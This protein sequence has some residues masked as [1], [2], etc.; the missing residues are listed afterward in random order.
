MESL[1]QDIR[2]AL[3]QL[4]RTPTLTC[5]ALFAL[6]L[7]IG[8]NVAI[9]STV[10]AVLLNSLPFRF[11]RQPDRLVSL[12]ETNPALLQV[13]A[14]RLGVT[15]NNF[16]WWRE[17][18]HSF[19]SIE[20][21]ADTALNMTSADHHEPERV[22]AVS[23]TPGFLP[24]LGVTPQLG[25]NLSPTP[26]VALISDDLWRSRF[27][28]DPHILGQRIHASD[29]TYQII[30][31][32]PKGFEL[33]ATGQGLDESRPK[34][35]IPLILRHQAQD[36]PGPSLTV[37][38]RL[39]PEVTVEQA[40]AEMQ[41]VATRLA[42]QHP[43]TNK[44]WGINVFP[45]ISEDVDP[46]LRTSLYVLQVAVGFVLLIACANVANLLL[47][48]AVAREREMAVRLAI[49]ASRWRILRQNLTESLL[50]STAAGV[51]G[52][53]LSLAL[54]RIVTF[55]APKEIHGLHEIGFN[56]LV[57]AFAIGVTF[58]SGL[59]FGLAPGLHAAHQSVAQALT[60]G[61]RSLV[62]S[63]KKFRGALVVIEI[64]MS[65][66]LL[67]GAGLTIRS[68]VALLHVDEGFRPDH[69][70]ILNLSLPAYRYQNPNQIAAFNDQLLARLQHLPGVQ[71]ASLSTA[72]PMRSLNEQS[73]ELPGVPSDPGKMKVTD[74]SM[75]TDQHVEAL[76]LHLLRGRNL[77]HADV[78][79]PLPD[80]ALVNEAFAK[81]NWP[82][83]DAL[84]KLFIFNGG[85]G[86]PV[87]FRIVGIF[88]NVHQFGPD[89]A[90]HTE[91]YVPSHHMQNM[92]LVVRCIGDP[93]ALANAVKQQ[94]W[95]L[96][97]DQPVDHV[98]SMEG[99]LSEWVSA[100]RFTMT[101]L[102]AFGVIALI[103][104]AVG[105]YSVL[106]YAVSLRTREIGVRVA[107]GAE[108]KRVASLILAE[109]L[110]LTLLGVVVGLAGAFLLTRFMQTLIFG[111]SAFDVT[112]FVAV[113]LLLSLIALLASYLPAR[114][115]SLINPTEALRVE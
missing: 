13:L 104:S 79:A 81:A 87:H 69:L 17:Q 100:R 57:L 27:S 62:G 97:R 42:Q 76:G 50:L 11:L 6:A 18:A 66:I 15:G 39:K 52:L 67:I 96:D 41:V 55:L 65:L 61:S 68:L 44:G 1:L 2:F 34:I 40:R 114:R 84:G 64:A 70:L 45:T 16:L 5:A 4:S 49:G 33:P 89:Q 72:L 98:T 71:A 9:F 23:A 29:T 12:Y 90:P 99:I 31:V 35:W 108:P 8:A 56:A 93:L 25:R 73:Y 26:G 111:I 30:G 20:G 94:I 75:I 7:G 43:D 82:N 54:I 46:D 22:D 102:I 28:S 86:K 36:Y 60:R 58:A 103:S 53:L 113:S 85:E 105:L 83:Q 115:A 19:T 110:G 37:I 10:N 21:Y 14:G 80:V 32:L 51:L 107:L 59:L 95:A 106:A 78:T 24:M 112:T 88:A 38:A 77:N 101:I 3:R 74:W 109:G 63:S 92:S 47:T 48:K 91:V